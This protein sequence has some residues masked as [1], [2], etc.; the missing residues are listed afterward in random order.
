MRT[1][2]LE[3]RQSMFAVMPDRP[4]SAPPSLRI[5]GPREHTNL[6][7]YFGRAGAP[8]VKAPPPLPRSDYRFPPLAGNPTRK[9]F[10][11]MLACSGTPLIHD[12]VPMTLNVD[13]MHSVREVE[14]SMRYH[15][16]ARIHVISPAWVLPS[17]RLLPLCASQGISVL[18]V[19][20]TNETG[21]VHV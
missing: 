6:N 11:I 15:T 10:Q 16:T 17:D 2:S 4:K 18:Q 7:V 3:T 5:T 12:G 21:A 14:L 1:R 19:V 20:V 13:A 9:L 8:P